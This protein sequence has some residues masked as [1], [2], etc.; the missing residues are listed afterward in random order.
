[1]YAMYTMKDQQIRAA[2]DEHWAAS[3]AGDL[4]KEHDIYADNVIVDYPQSM[5]RISGLQNIQAL[6][7]HHPSKPSG[8]KVRRI[9]GKG[10]LWITE[11]VTVYDG[12][13][14]VPTVSIMEFHDG[15]VIHETQYFAERFEPPAWRAQW[16]KLMSDM[17]EISQNQFD[18]S[19][20]IS[21][22]VI[23]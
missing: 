2:L 11:Y 19:E 1:M 17:V 22:P 4:E 23:E 10:D 7:G 12:Q 3:A 16:V 6:R 21:K 20:I 9:I 8:F 14:H 15:K 18:W 13:H 5:E